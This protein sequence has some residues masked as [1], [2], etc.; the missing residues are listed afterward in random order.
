MRPGAVWDRTLAVDL[1]ESAVAG[2]GAPCPLP[3][4]AP[5]AVTTVPMEGAARPSA[6]PVV[7]ADPESWET[8]DVVAA[9]LAT[10]CVFART[11]AD[12]VA[13]ACPLPAP[14]P[15]AATEAPID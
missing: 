1:P 12:G 6:S 15:R 11:D 8:L 5:R 10:A 3:T 2:D 7:R 14:A 13:P 9:L 4:P